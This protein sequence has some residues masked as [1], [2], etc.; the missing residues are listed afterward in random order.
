MKKALLASVAFVALASGA[1]VAADM[2]VK[3]P[4]LK[5]PPPPAY[6]WTGCYIGAN[7]GFDWARTSSHDA[8]VGS[9]YGNENDHSIA[10]GGQI[11]CDYQV[12]PSWVIGVRGDYD[13]T[14][15]NDGTHVIPAFPAFNYGNS[16]HYTATATGRIGYLWSPQFLLY[17]QGGA[18]WTNNNINVYVISPPGPSEFA[19]DRRTGWTVGV[20]GE[21][22]VAQNF[23]FFME[24][25]YMDFGTKNIL[26]T[27][28][29]GAVGTPSNLSIRENIYQFLVGVNCRFGGLGG[30]V[31]AKY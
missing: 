5:A 2:P 19:G 24:G 6:T 7:V 16:F 9:D 15:L 27:A 4:Y 21:Y 28:M 22:M 25:N 20:G 30:P 3:A 11:G 26:F 1:A 18:A 12:A 14:Q 8:I 17:V 10:G 13:W 29:P 23:S 31:V